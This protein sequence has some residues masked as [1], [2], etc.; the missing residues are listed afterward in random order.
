MLGFMNKCPHC[1]GKSSFTP[2][3]MECDKSLMLWCNH[4]GNFINQTLTLETIRRW[5][6]RHD[7]G[8]ESIE[9][10]LS[11]IQLEELLVLQ[12]KLNLESNR[13]ALENIEIHIK[14][15]TDY[16]YT[17]D[18]P[19]KEDYL[20]KYEV[21]F[22]NR[23]ACENQIFYVKA[24]NEADAERLFWVT[25]SKD[26]YYDCIEGISEKIEN[27]YYIEEGGSYEGSGNS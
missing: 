24:K 8:G 10:P 12:D 15:F 21:N 22:Y 18:E 6:I 14:D 4:C 9:P 26:S 17:E 16:L 19:P 27:D 23:F 20:K 5:W 25:H 1:G 7:E 13:V 2:E 11:K 3:E